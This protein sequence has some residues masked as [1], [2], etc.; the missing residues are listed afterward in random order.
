MESF[1]VWLQLILRYSHQLTPSL[2]RLL[3]SLGAVGAVGEVGNI[4][5]EAYVPSK[6]TRVF[7]M[8]AMAAGV[9][10]WYV[11]ALAYIHIS[12]QATKKSCQ[13]GFNLDKTYSW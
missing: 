9:E 12:I 13:P 3:R 2:A 11:A 10:F 1:L 8:P 5:E 6:V 7:A 4:G